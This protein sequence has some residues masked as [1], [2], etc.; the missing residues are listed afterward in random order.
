MAD[1]FTVNYKLRLPQLGKK[2]WKSDWDNN[3]TKIDQL[4]GGLIIDG[5]VC[6]KCATSI[7]PT[8]ISAFIESTTGDLTGAAS[9]PAGETAEIRIDHSADIVFDFPLDPI[10][11]APVG[12]NCI[13]VGDRTVALNASEY[14]GVFV[15]RVENHTG[16]TLLVTSVT[17]LRK[18][19]KLS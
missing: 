16:S 5:S 8:A 4:L 13:L 19:F 17:W 10:F 9:I 2:P 15:V 11:L 18:G 1:T 7:D 3:F 14:G 12:V 6:A